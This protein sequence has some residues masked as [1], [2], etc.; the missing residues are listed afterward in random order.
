MTLRVVL[1]AGAALVLVAFPAAGQSRFEVGRLRG[2]LGFE[3]GGIWLTRP[4]Q[5]GIA[6]RD[7]WE[8]FELGLSGAALDHRFLEFRA[9][10]R[11]TLRQSRAAESLQFGDEDANQTAFDV[12]VEILPTRPLSASFGA[13]RS[14]YTLRRETGLDTRANVT[15]AKG[16][17]RFRNAY[18]PI[19]ISYSSRSQDE[20]WRSGAMDPVGRNLLLQTGRL[21]AENRKTV[22]LLEH[23]VIAERNTAGDQGLDHRFALD[24][25]QLR[26]RLAWGKAS[27]LT[28]L[29]DYLKQTGAFA[30]QRLSWSEEVHLQHTRTTG[31]DLAWSQGWLTTPTSAVKNRGL[32]GSLRSEALRGLPVGL[33]ASSQSTEY[34]TGYENLTDLR[35]EATFR[36]KLPAGLALNAAVLVGYERYRLEATD[37]GW[38]TVVREEHTA[39]PS[40]RFLLENPSVDAGSVTVTSWDGTLAYV[41][42]LD[43][44]LVE[45]APFLEVAA[46]PGGRIAIGDSVVVS[47]RYR[48]FP[49]SRGDAVIG[50]YSVGLSTRWI[51]LYHRQTIRNT[52]GD[53]AT[54]GIALGYR[55][56][57]LNETVVGMRLL[58]RVAAGLLDLGAERTA[59]DLDGYSVT[60][61]QV[62][63]GFSMGLG[64]RVRYG[65]AATASTSKGTGGALRMLSGN[66]TLGWTPSPHLQVRAAFDFW[67]WIQEGRRDSR[68]AGGGLEA[69]WQAG[70]S[71]IEV[72]YDHR[73][74]RDAAYRLDD[75]VTVR[76]V[77]NL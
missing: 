24:R 47:Y 69:R 39:G 11:P 33:S 29:A 13:A 19:S 6:R 49:A 10:L 35:S 28:S 58:A 51:Q 17:L 67:R 14:R 50:S 36:T 56:S 60:S 68:F 20:Y 37:Q 70:L 18:L 22:V 48:V 57:D 44:E 62:R 61:S 71:Q 52:R 21:S 64:R 73:S 9:R 59:R 42:G 76:L 3:F 54:S 55:L 77:R 25:G 74:W 63:G 30:F 5:T 4:E 12:G 72:R 41:V 65:A 15:D 43:Y 31:T 1:V 38:V 66:A 46:L 26:H 32:R 40:G 8:W 7:Y 34:G 53:D 16:M 45:L 27:A 23:N 75:L 2:A